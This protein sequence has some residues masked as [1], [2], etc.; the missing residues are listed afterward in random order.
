MLLVKGSGVTG[1]ERKAEVLNAF[2]VP[3]INIKTS[4]PYDTQLL[5]QEVGKMRE[6]PTIQEEMVSVL[7]CQLDKHKSTC[8]GRI[9]P[10]G[11]RELV[12]TLN[13]LPAVL[14]NWR[15]QIRN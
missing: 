10:T 3:V 11:T 6:A 2:F 14:V 13:P 12:N 7:L 9:H 8:P 15:K 4:C 5:E 1:N